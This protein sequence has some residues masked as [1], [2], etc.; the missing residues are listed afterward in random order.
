MYKL[1][2]MRKYFFI[3]MFLTLLISCNSSDKNEDI[4]LKQAFKDIFYIGTALSEEQILGEDEAA[5]EV[6]KSNF[7]SITAENIMKSEVMQ[8][9]EGEFDFTLSDKFVE[10]GEQN[11]M[12]IIGHTLIWHSQAPDWF[13]VD[14]NGD[15]VSPEVLTQRM[16]SH[17]LTIAGRYKGRIHGWDVVNEAIEDDG[18]WRKSKFYEILGEDFIRIAFEL[19]HEADPDAELYYNDYSM[20]NEGRRN[21]VVS[22]VKALQEQGV[23]IDGIGMQ[24]HLNLNSPSIEDYE[25]SIQEFADLGVKIMITELD[26]SVLP[27]VRSN[28]GANVKSTFEYNE[29]INPYKDGL[30]KEV[31]EKQ[32]QRYTDFFKLFVKYQDNIDR[33]TLWGVNDAQSWKNDWPVE[34]RTDYTLLFDRNNKPKEVVKDIINIVSNNN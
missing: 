24:G 9:I 16:R 27:S 20:A 17:I 22:M 1:S 34:G 14:E 25:K 15:D 19:A 13:F 5:I 18:S 8:P 3:A 30:S 21:R 29:K 4:T 10:F 23:K 2:I 28:D 31:E 11:D 12:Q 26:L 7:N 33:V 6:V 32:Y